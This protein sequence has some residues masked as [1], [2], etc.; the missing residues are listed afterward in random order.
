VV[1]AATVL[2]RRAD[3]QPWPCRSA[4]LVAFHCRSRGAVGHA[5]QGFSFWA[6]AEAVAIASVAYSDPLS[7]R[8]S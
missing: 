6:I 4:W 1:G 5:A 7:N 8:P 3:G 2:H